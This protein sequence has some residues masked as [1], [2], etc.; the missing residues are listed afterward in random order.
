LKTVLFKE[1]LP[2][3]N[4]WDDHHHFFVCV[5]A[6]LYLLQEGDGELVCI[7]VGGYPLQALLEGAWDNKQLGSSDFTFRTRI[8]AAGAKDGKW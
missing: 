4:F 6:A 1:T 7:D 5:F 8:K 3:G 2:S